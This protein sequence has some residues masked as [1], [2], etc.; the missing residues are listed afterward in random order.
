M[1][2]LLTL[3]LAMTMMMSLVACGNDNT[4]EEV[5]DDDTVL[6]EVEPNEDELDGNM[7]LDEEDLEGMEP[8]ADPSDDIVPPADNEE[9]AQPPMTAPEGYEPVPQEP[10]VTEPAPTTPDVEETPEDSGAT[11]DALMDAMNTIISAVNS[12]MMTETM[13]LPSDM[14]SAFLF[15]DYVDG[16]RAIASQAMMGSIAH[17]VVLLEVPAGTDVQSVADAIDANKDPR[18]WICVEAEVA[19]V[20]V[21]GNMILLVMSDTASADAIMASFKTL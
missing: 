4:E 10:E 19:E 11:S 12:E 1:K 15:I 16:Y 14:Y 20:L 3:L 13:E 8:A 18:K 2:K 21:S 5:L 9:P 6:E 7:D 17:S